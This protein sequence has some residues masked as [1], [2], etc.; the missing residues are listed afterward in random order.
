MSPTV[1]I[2][3]QRERKETHCVMEWLNRHDGNGRG[4]LKMIMAE[5][6][7]G[8]RGPFYN[9]DDYPSLLMLLIMTAKCLER[10]EKTNMQKFLQ[11]CMI[12]VAL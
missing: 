5:G 8:I 11:I 12:L 1:I 6:L 4:R 3:G 2:R 7:R 10:E 9:A